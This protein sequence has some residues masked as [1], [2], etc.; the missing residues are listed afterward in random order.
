MYD[1]LLFFS[2]FRN[3]FWIMFGDTLGTQT[4]ILIF[5]LRYYV[6]I[7]TSERDSMY[8]GLYSQF[9]LLVIPLSWVA[10]DSLVLRCAIL[11]Q[12]VFEECLKQYSAV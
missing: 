12:V 7:T 5:G 11:H 2:G 4:V 9:H 10:E 3:N 6:C 8:P 1:V